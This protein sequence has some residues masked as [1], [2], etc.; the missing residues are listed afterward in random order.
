MILTIE[1]SPELE[2]KLESEAMHRGI[3]KDELNESC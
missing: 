3:S 1:V 2:N